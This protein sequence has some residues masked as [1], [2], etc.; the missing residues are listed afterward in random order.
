MVTQNDISTRGE[1]APLLE[2]IRRLAHTVKA[3]L[4]R[5]LTD[6]S[7][8]IA[9]EANSKSIDAEKILNA[10][11]QL[12][13]ALRHREV[14]LSFSPT[15]CEQLDK[16]MAAINPKLA[17]EAAERNARFLEWLDKEMGRMDREEK[18]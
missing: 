4:F 17:A 9:I 12:A 10:V 2:N 7:F 11:A 6:A 3:G 18:A 15:T 16:V 1:I 13:Y 5:D 14:L 8:N